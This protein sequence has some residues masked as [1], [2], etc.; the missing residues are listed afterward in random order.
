M[1][2]GEESEHLPDSIPQQRSYNGYS[3][4]EQLPRLS[5]LLRRQHFAV[6]RSFVFMKQLKLAEPL[7]LISDFSSSVGSVVVR[8]SNDQLRKLHTSYPLPSFVASGKVAKLCSFECG[9]STL[10]FFIALLN[11]RVKLI[12]IGELCR[13]PWSPQYQLKLSPINLSHHQD[14]CYSFHQYVKCMALAC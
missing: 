8:H 10:K 12:C 7:D 2:P 13:H 1:R 5:L 3:N 14:N 6:W 11:V 9:P 4:N